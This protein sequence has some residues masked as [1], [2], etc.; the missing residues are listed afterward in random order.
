MKTKFLVALAITATLVTRPGF[1][2]AVHSFVIT[3]SS[4]TSLTVSYDGLP[5]TASFEGPDGWKFRF[6]Q[7]FF[8]MLLDMCN[9]P[10]R[11]F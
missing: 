1:A 4:L 10:N 6:P 11:N 2:G 3:E 7:V 8:L 5:L 9:G